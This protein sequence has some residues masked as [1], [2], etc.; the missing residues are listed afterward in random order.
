MNTHDTRSP[1]TLAQLEQRDDFIG[2][3]VGPDIAETRAMLDALGLESLDQLID[4][5]I[6]ASILSSSPLA[7]PEG[8]SEPEALAMLREIAPGI[9]WV[10]ALLASMLSLNSLFAGDLADGSLE[11]ML[12]APESPIAL[13]IA[14]C[15][16][17][18]LLS[19]L[20]L[21]VA[22]PVVG[23]LFGL[24]QSGS[25][26]VARREPH[27][28]GHAGGDQQQVVELPQEGDEIGD[29]VDGAERIA[30]HQQGHQARQL[31]RARLAHQLP[32]RDQVGGQ[33]GRVQ[34]A[35]P[36]RQGSHAGIGP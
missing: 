17:H 26:D 13:V 9:V 16:A 22:A 1:A 11:Q 8:R 10:C 35:P 36:A 25:P 5:V 21:I 20:P 18:W 15:C 14:K 4:K 19:G 34:T 27:H 23:L 2:R 30:Q 24:A 31:G 33:A 12:L 29:Q 3:H 7:L 32:Q 28:Q 6:P